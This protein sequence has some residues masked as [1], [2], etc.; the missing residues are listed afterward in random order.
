MR[1]DH[2]VET[3]RRAVSRRDVPA[4]VSSTDTSRYRGYR[5][6]S[7][8]LPRWDYA[9]NGYYFVTICTRNKLPTLGE[10]ADGRV[11]LSPAGSIVDEKWRKTAEVRP[12]VTLDEYT[13]MPNQV[14][15]ILI[16]HDRHPQERQSDVETSRRDVS[17]SARPHLIAGSLGAIIGQFKSVATKRIRDRADP[18]FGWQP[19]FYDHIIRDN[20]EFHRIR[21]YIVENPVKWV[22]DRETLENLWM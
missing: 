15:G 6:E 12:C 19:R 11:V 4:Q 22:I 21:Q 9:G 10:V 17:T 2:A 1:R 8:R 18:G 13:V 20:D 3:S 7:T 5:P 16:I 14:H